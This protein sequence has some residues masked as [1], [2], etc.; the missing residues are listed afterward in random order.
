M[1]AALIMAGGCLIPF[2]AP[3]MVANMGIT[4]TDLLTIC[5]RPGMRLRNLGVAASDHP[6]LPAFSEGAY[7][8]FLLFD[9]G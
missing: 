2:I 1:G 4:E 9:V 7:L 8:K 3:S 6:V 5:A